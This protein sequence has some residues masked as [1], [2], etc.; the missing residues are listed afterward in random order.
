M[1]IQLFEDL[2]NNPINTLIYIG[3]FSFILL[4]S[5]YYFA[6]SEDIF[7]NFNIYHQLTKQ[8]FTISSGSQRLLYYPLTYK[9]LSDQGLIHFLFGLGPGMYGSDAGMRLNTPWSEYLGNVFG[10]LDAGF[11]PYVS[12]QIIPIWGELG[13]IGL[14]VFFWMFFKI[15]ST[16][17]HD[18]SIV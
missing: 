15:L 13:I 14:F 18:K 7:Y 1:I 2:I 11:D 16:A 8:E 12:S 5:I 17:K 4:I 10:Q 6:S 3:I 9:I